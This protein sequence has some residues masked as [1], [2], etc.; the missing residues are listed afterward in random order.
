MGKRLPDEPV[1][2]LKKLPWKEYIKTR[3]WK[4]FTKSLTDNPD[5]T[6]ELC[7][8]KRWGNVIT[9]GKNKGKRR[10]LRQFH[11]HHLNYEHLGEETREDVLTLCA[12]CHTTCHD[13]EM[14][15]RSRGGFWTEIYQFI[16]D[17]T[18][19]AYE[20]FKDRNNK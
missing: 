5:C 8:C 18:P 9:R 6:C 12:K 14:L 2:E 19:W 17:H 15:S 20:P 16:L 3:H 10:R 13:V 4:R 1:E 7:G 11:T